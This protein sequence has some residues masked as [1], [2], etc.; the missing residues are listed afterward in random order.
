MKP[1]LNSLNFQLN[2]RPLI[3]YLQPWSSCYHFLF[4]FLICLNLDN[5][6]HLIDMV[7]GLRQLKVSEWWCNCFIEDSPVTVDISMLHLTVFLCSSQITS[8][9]LTV[10]RK[11]NS[12]TNWS[13]FNEVIV[14]YRP[15]TE[16]C[17]WSLSTYC[18]DLPVAL[19][20]W[21]FRPC[22]LLLVSTSASFL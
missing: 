11:K 5:K 13:N 15:V 8:W 12:S 4:L 3:V 10:E 2:T 9:S 7:S 16:I 21:A 17:I 22:N 14:T 1:C 18:N 6:T 20:L 19:R